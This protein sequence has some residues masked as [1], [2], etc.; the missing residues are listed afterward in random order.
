[1]WRKENAPTLLV[2]VYIG[3]ATVANCMDFLRKLKMEL[4]YDPAFPFLGVYPDKTIIQKHTC[5]IN[6]HSSTAHSAQDTGTNIHQPM[7]G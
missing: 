5:A 1:M 4:P 7:S 2:G 6:V 3:I